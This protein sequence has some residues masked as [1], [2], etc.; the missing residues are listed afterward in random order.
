VPRPSDADF[1]AGLRPKVL[2]TSRNKGVNVKVLK[3]DFLRLL[4]IAERAVPADPTRLA[5]EGRALPQ[6][7]RR[8]LGQRNELAR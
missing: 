4:A 2:Y 8:R 6:M 5:T 1:V 3:E 7:G